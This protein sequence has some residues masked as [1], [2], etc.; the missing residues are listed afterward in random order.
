MTWEQNELNTVLNKR[1]FAILRVR[2]EK[3]RVFVLQNRDYPEA[4]GT[5]MDWDVYLE[6]YCRI[7]PEQERKKLRASLS[8]AALLAA[9]ESGSHRFS[10]DFS[11]LKGRRTNW[12][13]VSAVLDR[14]PGE[15]WCADLFVWQSNKEHFLRSIIDMYVYDTC[16]Y[17]IYLDMRHNSY[18]MFSSN[19]LERSR[20][21][22][23]GGDYENAVAE[24]AQKYVVPEDRE[25]AIKKMCLKH[26]A[27]Q[28]AENEMYAF[29]VGVEDPV[30]GYTRKQLS[31][32]YYDRGAGTVLLC[33]TD[34]TEVYLEERA[35]QK[36]L[37]AARLQAETDPLTGIFNYG[38]I[39]RRI[40]EILAGGTEEAALLVLDLDNFKHVN[41][42]L[43][44]QEGDRLLW[45]V[46]QTIQLHTGADG[47]QGRIGGDEFVVFLYGAGIRK[48]AEECAGKICEAVHCLSLPENGPH[49]VSCSIG[50]AFAPEEGKDYQTLFRM[51]DQRAYQAKRLGRNC[52]LLDS[53]GEKAGQI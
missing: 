23:S 42:T 38:G 10:M 16:D 11:Y 39:S 45:K 34:V 24:Y 25:A 51:A 37:E 53:Q 33:R 40:E 20:I 36:E 8:Q 43:G 41:D 52:Y 50:G 44:H 14:Q 49:S 12:V 30:R 46:A 17:F 35:R 21:P 22:V 6:R 3:N 5:E 13:T 15:D 47:L 1:F 27:K 2:P 26:V 48:Q 29:T 31:Y 19:P 28:L 9:A 4:V 7:L 18:V 32:R